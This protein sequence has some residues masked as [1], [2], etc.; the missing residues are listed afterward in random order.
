ATEFLDA[1]LVI[2][3][4]DV[5]LGGHASLAALRRNLEHSPVAV[6][7]LGEAEFPDASGLA[8][9][10]LAEVRL[11]APESADR[12]VLWQRA[13]GELT[14]ADDVEPG[15]LANQYP[16]SPAQIANAALD[17]K[18][19]YDADEALSHAVLSNT[20]SLQLRADLS[21]FARPRST[22]LTL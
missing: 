21:E 9:R 5:W 3:Q 12:E 17:A 19:R 15:L 7:M 20:S 13:L 18:L 6:A 8:W 4:V 2:D 14:L 16:L 1:L 11:A 10:S 22:R